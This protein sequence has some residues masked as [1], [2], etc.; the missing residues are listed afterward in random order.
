LFSPCLNPL[1]ISCVLVNT[2]GKRHR[3]FEKLDG[4]TG[5]GG[6]LQKLTVR[7]GIGRTVAIELA[8]PRAGLGGKA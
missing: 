7:I 1:F 4:K 3:C 8:D 2:V 5:Y 6:C